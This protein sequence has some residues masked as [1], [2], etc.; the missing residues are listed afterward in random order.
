MTMR[1]I[2]TAM[3]FASSAMLWAQT[4][5]PFLSISGVDHRQV[6]DGTYSREHN[7]IL[8]YSLRP[9]VIKPE[10]LAFRAEE[11]TIATWFAPRT[12]AGGYRMIAYKGDRSRDPQAVDFKFG[13]IN[14]VP[15]FG[16]M[17]AQGSWDGIL[18][19]HNDLLIPP[20]K[21]IPLKDCPKVRPDHWNFMAVTFNRGELKLFLNGELLAA[22]QTTTKA[23]NF[24]DTPLWLGVSEGAGGLKGYNL[25]GLI[26]RID[27]F[28]AA[29]PDDA[30]LARWQKQRPEYPTEK[31]S[32][33]GPEI[34]FPDEYDPDFKKKLK[35]VEEYE[36]AIPASSLPDHSP[37]MTVIEFGG[38]PVLARDGIR[39]SGMCMMPQYSSGDDAVFNAG[40]DFAAAGVNYFSDIY[41]TWPAQDPKGPQMRCANLWPAPG[42]YDFARLEAR[43]QAAVDANPNVRI[44]LRIKMDMPEWWLKEHPEEVAIDEHGNRANQVTLS[45]ELWLKDICKVHGDFIRHLENSRFAKHIVGYVPGGGHASEWFWYGREKGFIDYSEGHT[46]RFRAWL[47]ER[48]QTDDALRQAW[49]DP[50]VSLATAAVPSPA[51]RRASEDGVFRDLAVARP[52]VDHRM[53]L[54]YATTRAQAAIARAIRANTAARKLVGF[55]YG[56]S[57][58][59]G[60]LDN[61]GFQN[62][63]VA[64][65]NP[66]IDFFCSPF[67]Y[68]RRRGGQEGDFISS[69]TAS[70]R[71]H[72]KLYWDE[73][74]LRTHLAVN[75]MD[76]H[77]TETPDETDAVLWRSYGN[78]LVYGTNLWW[79]LIIHRA[80][81]HS[82]RIMNAIQRMAQLDAELLDVPKAP[83]AEIAVMRDEKS[84]YYSNSNQDDVIRHY[85]ASMDKEFA[86]IGAPYDNY[87]LSDIDHPRM[88]DYKVYIF[89]NAFHVPPA[90]RAAIQRKLSRNQATAVWMYAP[91]YVSDEGNSTDH[92]RALTGIGFAKYQLDDKP[93]WEKHASAGALAASLP[94]VISAIR[95]N[96][97]FAVA[98]GDAT[99]LASLGG[100]PA[101]AVK[102]TPWG[103]A[104]YLLPPAKA[105]FLREVCRTAGVHI[106]S[107]TGDILR[108]NQNFVMLHT[109][110][111]GQKTITLPHPAKLRDLQ[112]DT[113]SPASASHSFDLAEQKTAL[114]QI[115]AP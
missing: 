56:Y 31:L 65:A 100:K 17:D 60:G 45:S 38:V 99:A 55:F 15:E 83:A 6:E 90:L 10:A 64:I 94:D 78:S 20:G 4:P 13:M 25:L 14:M 40:R 66:D 102:T 62:M 106:Y 46:Q 35:I 54:N 58:Y 51:L 33:P 27:F 7:A 48:Y 3:A 32:I 43:L 101:A 50:A 114:F 107:E 49:N 88:P 39:E 89:M 96:P 91:G 68:A 115:L 73:V 12:G 108:A 81:F 26:H 30:I 42:Q 59:V 86:R 95:F 29:L 74:D 36:K 16:F 84:F 2:F 85:K 82:D 111:P 34:N 52:V 24:Q 61:M 57:M 80:V 109:D 70:L 8:N 1:M 21:R 105:D 104:V 41:Y 79:F 98:D 110:K 18:R 11:L 19:N 67:S 69:F 9:T 63:D 37:E 5:A 76:T 92:M 97:A 103:R 53:F 113:V 71:L 87:L 47:K 22:A 72:G 44:L 75:N 77:K 93:A 23:L 112:T 28:N